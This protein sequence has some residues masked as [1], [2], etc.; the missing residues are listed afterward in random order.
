MIDKLEGY[1]V[2]FFEVGVTVIGLIMI[3][4]VKD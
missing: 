2:S 3:R 1:N 4:G